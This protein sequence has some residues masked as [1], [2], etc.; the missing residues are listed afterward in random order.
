MQ[1]AKNGRMVLEL[2]KM[3]FLE[4]KVKPN[5]VAS[6]A[7]LMIQC[8]FEYLRAIYLIDFEHFG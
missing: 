3:R 7:N 8:G 2:N 6:H 5:L 1:V 4:P